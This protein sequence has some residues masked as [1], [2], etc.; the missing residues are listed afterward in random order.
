MIEKGEL[1]VWKHFTGWTNPDCGKTLLV[2]DIVEPKS[3]GAATWVSCMQ[4]GKAFMHERG[5]LERL[6]VS[7][8]RLENSQKPEYNNLQEEVKE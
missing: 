5:S 7:I 2:L 3:R 6:T 1:R 8:N 4:E